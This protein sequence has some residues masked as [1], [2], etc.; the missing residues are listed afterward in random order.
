M[1][2]VISRW[3]FDPKQEEQVMTKSKDL[4]QKIRSWDG[5]IEAYDVRVAPGAVLAVLTYRD[6]ESYHKLVKDPNGPF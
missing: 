4:M 1:F 2:T 5:V 6:E 3:E